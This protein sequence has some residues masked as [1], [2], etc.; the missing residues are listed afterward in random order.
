MRIAL[1]HLSPVPGDLERNRRLID[2]GIEEACKRNADW[3][4]V[5]EAGLTGY[6]FTPVIGVEWIVPATQDAWIDSVCKVSERAGVAIFLSVPE[7]DAST[8]LLHNSTHVIVRGSIVGTQRK[9][10]CMPGPGEGWSIPGP[11][12]PQPIAVDGVSVG[13]LI[14]ADAYPLQNAIACKE[15]GASV[16]LSPASWAEGSHGPNGEWEAD[17]QHTGLPMIVCNRSGYES[18]DLNFTGSHSAVI[19]NGKRKLDA[20]PSSAS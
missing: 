5:P 7:K 10:L 6:F 2:A 12:P 20:A 8:G 9:I 11:A 19:V 1:L 4:V 3:V 14:C 17:S 16:L 18:S 15:A 13:V